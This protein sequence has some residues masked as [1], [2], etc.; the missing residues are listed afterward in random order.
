MQQDSMSP[1]LKMK[2]AKLKRPPEHKKR[3][4]TTTNNAAYNTKTKHKPTTL[5][6]S[7]EKRVTR[8]AESIQITVTSK[9]A[10]GI[11]N[12]LL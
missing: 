8:L 2:Q 9:N 7:I 3:N 5:E 10:W 6:Q 4:K 1:V 11:N 12:Q